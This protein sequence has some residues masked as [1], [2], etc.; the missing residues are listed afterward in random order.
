MVQ[1]IEVWVIVDENGDY[2]TGHDQESAGTAYDD[3]IGSASGTARRAI[4][5]MLS[6]PLP[7]PVEL[8][9][10]VPVEGDAE[11]SVA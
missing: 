10:T 1:Q 7:V 5:V 6:V 11:L 4:K 8:T 9:G 2:S 3:N